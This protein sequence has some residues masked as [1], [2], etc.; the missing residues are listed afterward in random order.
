MRELVDRGR[1]AFAMARSGGLREV[2]RRVRYGSK[3]DIFAKFEFLRGDT[4]IAES[5]AEPPSSNTVNWVLP[6]FTAGSGGH[7]NALRFLGMLTE[8]GYDCRVVIDAGSWFGESSD[9]TTRLQLFFGLTGIPVY[10]GVTTA[11]PAFAVVATGWHQAHA[12]QNAMPARER[13]YFVQDFEP[14]F[15]ARGSEFTFAEETYRFGFTG[16]T[17]GTWLADKLRS[18]YGMTCYPVGF[19]YDKA[20]YAPGPTRKRGR[21]RIFFYARPS[22]ER[23]AF[24]MGL[25]AFAT[26]CTSIPEVMPVF[27]GF[28]LSAFVIPFEH[29]SWGV[30]G[31]AALPDLYR[32]CDLALVISLTNLSLLPLELMACG[33]PVVSNNGPWTEWLLNSQN[34]VLADANAASLADAM[35]SLLQS[36]PERARLVAAG[37]AFARSTSWDDA[38][39]EMASA[40][41]RRGC[42]PVRPSSPPKV[43]EVRDHG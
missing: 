24:E 37:I 3:E 31:I 33:T 4:S 11:P 21:R 41:A 29:E 27:A 22:T 17:A 7:I 2:I 6:A 20:V 19:S 12:V 23:R 42:V 18:E 5:I 26:L 28:D 32:S 30:L 36:D 1:R 43:D 40:L 10:V 25:L 38:G 13:F 15:Y 35:Q 14:W 9:V 34:A 16:I 39:D 8:R